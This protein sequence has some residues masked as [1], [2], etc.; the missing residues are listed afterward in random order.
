MGIKEHVAKSKYNN[1]YKS[2]KYTQMIGLKKPGSSE[3]SLIGFVVSRKM[4]TLA[5]SKD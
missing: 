3:S 1:Y 2:K 4:L 5:F